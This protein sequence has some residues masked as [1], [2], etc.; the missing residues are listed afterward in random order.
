MIVP[1]GNDVL[2]GAGAWFRYSV[3]APAVWIVPALLIAYLTTQHRLPAGQPILVAMAIAFVLATAIAI[4]LVSRLG[5][6][7]LR[8]VTLIPVV[9]SVA[10][11]LRLGSTSLDQTLSVRPLALEIARIQTHPLP[12]AVNGVPREI[13]YGLTFYRNQLTIRYEWGRVPPEEHLLVAPENSLSEVSKQVGGRHVSFLGHYAPQ[14]VD[15]FW[16][17]AAGGPSKN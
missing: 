16:I 17:A 10:A 14:H 9:L 13:E 2:P 11:V 15:Y 3:R 8:F 6:R 4:T 1:T 5:L 7:M 12:L